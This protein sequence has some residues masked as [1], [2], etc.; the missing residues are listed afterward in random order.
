MSGSAVAMM[1]V[2]MLAIWGGLVVALLNLR[3]S[4]SQSK[5]NHAE[6]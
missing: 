5:G 4:D 6:S 3:R 2:S 1:L